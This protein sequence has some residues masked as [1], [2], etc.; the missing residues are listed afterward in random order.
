MQFAEFTDRLRGEIVPLGVLDRARLQGEAAERAEQAEA[1]GKRQEAIERAEQRAMAMAA[2][3][4][5]EIARQGYSNRELAEYTQRREA[6][7]AERINVLRAEINRLE[8]RSPDA[9]LTTQR[10][11]GLFPEENLVARARQMSADPVMLRAVAD[12]DTRRE[13]ARREA[14]RAETARLER[15]FQ[16]ETSRLV[17]AVEGEADWPEIRRLQRGIHGSITRDCDTGFRIL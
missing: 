17:R 7:K 9:P 8:G 12:Y 2:A 4:R 3:E 13:T 1:D 14:R 16:A 10:S 5:A 15:A 6:D 11:A